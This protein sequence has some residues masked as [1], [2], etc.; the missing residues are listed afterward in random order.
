MFFELQGEAFLPSLSRINK[1]GLRTTNDYSIDYTFMDRRNPES[2]LTRQPES[3]LT[4]ENCWLTLFTGAYFKPHNRS[5]LEMYGTLKSFIGPASVP[6]IFIALFSLSC[7]AWCIFTAG[8]LI[9]LLGADKF[10]VNFLFDLPIFDHMRNLYFLQQYFQFCLIIVAALGFNIMM[11]KSSK[12][13]EK[14]FIWVSLV[15]FL[16]CF[17][18]PLLFPILFSEKGSIILKEYTYSSF[19]LACIVMLAFILRIKLKKIKPSKNC[20]TS[21]LVITII[22]GFLSNTLISKYHEPLQGTLTND[23][24]LLSLRDRTN[25]FLKFRFERPNKMEKAINNYGDLYSAHYSNS[26]MTDNSYDHP[27]GN[28][29][30][31]TPTK[32]LLFRSIFG[33]ELFLSK[34]FFM[35]PQVFVS[36]NRKDMSLFLKQ[37]GL[38]VEFLNKGIGLSDEAEKIA[39]LGKID[40]NMLDKF[41]ETPQN[42]DLNIEVKEYNAN[43]MHFRVSNKLAGLFVYTDLW[44]KDWRVEVDG[45]PSPLRKAFF[46]FKGVELQPGTHDV[47][48]IFTSKIE[49]LMVTMNLFFIILLIILP[50][51]YVLPNKNYMRR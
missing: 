2:N 20:A 19:G 15:F 48:F 43:S 1:E 26:T 33:N 47:R 8:I 45:N 32:F 11:E 36:D 44:E 22:V 14:A 12:H 4:G 30:F 28:G 46:T 25:H 38:L 41:S 35:L 5:N 7:V 10:P 9:S 27:I 18:L 21:I 31:M 6:F 40:L 23:L 17:S 51:M 49:H 3:F 39:N 16:A 24:N 50:V 34:K 37:P 42:S 13:L 29:G